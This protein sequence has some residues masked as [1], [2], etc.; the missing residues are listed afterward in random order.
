MDIL[1]VAKIC[2]AVNKAFCEY[3]GDMSQ[4]PWAEAAD[5]QREAAVEAV[6]KRFANPGASSA[7]ESHAEWMRHKL[8]T[9]WVYGPVKDDKASPP[10]HPDIVPFD[11]LPA[12]AQF[13]D[14]LINAVIDAAVG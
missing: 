6:T 2:H 3:C 10:T 1:T 4:K 14:T 5:W 7:R 8:E 12:A 11:Q 9:G 13:K